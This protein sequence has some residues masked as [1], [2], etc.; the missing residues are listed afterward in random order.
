MIYASKEWESAQQ[1]TKQRSPLPIAPLPTVVMPPDTSFCN[2]D[3]SWKR[4]TKL[5]RLGWVFRNQE[6]IELNR[7]SSFQDHVSSALL[8]EALAIQ[9]ALIHAS[10]LNIT[11]ICLRIDSQVLVRAVATGRRPSE[12]F[13]VLS[14]VNSLVSP[15]S[16]IFTCHRF[17]FIPRSCNG[18]AYSIAK[19]A[20]ISLWVQ[21]H[22][23]F[24]ILN[25]IIS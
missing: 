9:E 16:S 18:L 1:A 7:G 17:F 15:P 22:K 10:S 8:A 3:D 6:G 23:L 25:E 21:G 5:A 20:Y 14:D 4:D 12:L 13:G 19:V 24:S 2:T 11:N